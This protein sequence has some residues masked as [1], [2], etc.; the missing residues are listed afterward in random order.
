MVRIFEIILGII[1]LG[2][3]LNGYIVLFGYEAVLPTSPE[4]MDFLGTGYLLAIEKTTEII[5]GSLL[6][7]RRY[8]PLSLIVLAGIIVNIF[9]FHLFVDH[10]LL[11]VA[12][13][14]VILECILLWHYRVNFMSLLE[15]NPIIKKD[16]SA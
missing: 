14:L 13:L 4:A 2:A 7:I 5:C 8:V 1:F 3:G 15:K 12:I 10:A 9:A 11:P 6:L 16:K